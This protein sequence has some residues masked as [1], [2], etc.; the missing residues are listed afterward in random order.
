MGSNDITNIAYCVPIDISGEMIENVAIATTLGDT[1][2]PVANGMMRLVL[3]FT[4]FFVMLIVTMVGAPFIY[5][6]FVYDY[7]KNSINNSGN[8]RN[9]DTAEKLKGFH[10]ILLGVMGFFGFFLILNAFINHIASQMIIGLFVIIFIIIFVGRI[11]LYLEDIKNGPGP[12]SDKKEII[13]TLLNGLNNYN[14][15]FFITDNFPYNLF[16]LVL[17]FVEGLSMYLT[18]SNVEIWPYF[19][20]LIFLDIYVVNLYINSERVARV[21]P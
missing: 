14:I 20:F 13:T 6:N 7:I 8:T 19:L 17:V 21:N 18:S 16:A 12:E 1:N 9:Q 3:N 5:D 11:Y 2:D 4:A 10:L 15:S